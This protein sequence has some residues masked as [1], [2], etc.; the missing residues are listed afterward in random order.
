MLLCKNSPWVKDITDFSY[1][2][3]IWAFFEAEMV[4]IWEKKKP[5]SAGIIYIMSCLSHCFP[6]CA[7]Q[8]PMDHGV[9]SGKNCL[10]KQTPPQVGWNLLFDIKVITN[11][12][13]F[14]GISAGWRNF[15]TWVYTSYLEMIWHFPTSTRTISVRGEGGEGGVRGRT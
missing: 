13:T 1:L 3:C 5:R 8:M 15:N 10:R 11:I 14:W 6:V 2:T 7:S 4:F 9:E 12:K